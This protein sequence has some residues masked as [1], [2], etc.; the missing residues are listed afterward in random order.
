MTTTFHADV[1]ELD[2]QFLKTLKTA[3]KGQKVEIVVTPSDDTEYLA[4]NPAYR[5]LLL[6]R[7]EEIKSGGKLVTPDQSLFQ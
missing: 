4:R 1:D 3:F 6:R 7:M 2:E 5:D